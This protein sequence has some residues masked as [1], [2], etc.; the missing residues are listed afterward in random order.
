VVVE[1]QCGG[2]WLREVL[3]FRMN[4]RVYIQGKVE[5]EC[6]KAISKCPGW[7]VSMMIKVCK[8]L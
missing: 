7:D 3:L 8:Q 5:L 6:I 2:S 4:Y 1:L